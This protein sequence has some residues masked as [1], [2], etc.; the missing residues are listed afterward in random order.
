MLREALFLHQLETLPDLG[1]VAL[2]PR[3]GVPEIKVDIVQLKIV[4]LLLQLG[5]YSFCCAT[6]R[7]LCELEE[8]GGN[9]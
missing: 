2:I 4:E 3:R 6:G 7:D 9:K 8:L 1:N 5:F